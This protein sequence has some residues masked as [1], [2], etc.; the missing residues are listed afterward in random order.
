MVVLAVAK[1]AAA[2]LPVAQSFP[3]LSEEVPAV[4]VVVFNIVVPIVVPVG[5]RGEA[6]P[7]EEE[8]EEVVVSG[9]EVTSA[10]ASIRV[11]ASRRVLRLRCSSIRRVISSLRWRMAMQNFELARIRGPCQRKTKGMMHISVARPPR[12]EQAPAM[13]RRANMG[14]VARGRTVARREREVEAAALAEAAK[15]SYASVR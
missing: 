13:P 14:A 10:A 15:I 8:E 12:R 4:V 5:E 7:G 6:G 11:L 9:E 3:L 2:P 1:V